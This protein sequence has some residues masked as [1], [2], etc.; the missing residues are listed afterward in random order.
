MGSFLNMTFVLRA[1][2]IHS[3]KQFHGSVST[4]INKS[5]TLSLCFKKSYFFNMI[6]SIDLIFCKMI[7]ITEQNFFNS[8][9]F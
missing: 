2:L 1:S 5:L 7:E 9:D 4:Q 8:A 3:D 6:Q